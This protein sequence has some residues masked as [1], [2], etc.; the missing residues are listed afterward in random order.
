MNG[1]KGGRE[2]NGGR[3]EVEAKRGDGTGRKRRIV[4]SGRKG[5]RESNGRGEGRSERDMG[6]EGS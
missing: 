4:M 6:R 2:S 3:G 5:E 1:R